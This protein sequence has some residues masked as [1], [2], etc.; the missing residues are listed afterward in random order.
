MYSCFKNCSESCSISLYTQVAPVAWV[1]MTIFDYA[2]KLQTGRV[3]L[4]A[5]PIVTELEEAVHYMGS[6]VLNSSTSECVTLDI[7]IPVP[8]L[9]P[10][11]KGKPIMYP[12]YDQIRK[13]AH[14][15]A[16]VAI[17]AVSAVIVIR[18]CGFT[19]C[20]FAPK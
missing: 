2:S 6:A 3:T 11:N 18:A 15:V 7:E 4:H 10:F 19:E 16:Q 20:P 14:E 12:S 17:P 13:F 8:Q 5:W 1:N 9:Q